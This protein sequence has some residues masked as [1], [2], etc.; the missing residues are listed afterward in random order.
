MVCDG[1]SRNDINDSAKQNRSRGWN[2]Y[3]VHLSS[4]AERTGKNQKT[5]A[6]VSVKSKGVNKLV[7]V[8]NV[9]S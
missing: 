6:V 9:A 4:K 8:A 3:A 2:P 5:K 7:G 1:Q